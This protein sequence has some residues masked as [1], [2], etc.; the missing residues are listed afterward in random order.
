MALVLHPNVWSAHGAWQIRVMQRS[1]VEAGLIV[2]DPTD[3]W[4]QALVA[5]D[6]VI[7]DHGSVTLYGAATGHPVL[8]GAFG[9]ESVPGTAGQA[10]RTAAGWLDDDGAPLRPRLE[11]ALSAHGDHPDRFTE[12]TARAFVEPGMA[13]PR[14]RELAYDLLR[15][16]QPRH[17]PVR[18]AQGPR[19][20]RAFPLP[21]SQHAARARSFLVHTTVV[22]DDGVRGAGVRDDATAMGELHVHVSRL[23]AGLAAEPVEEGTSFWHLACDIDEPDTRLT[24]SASVVSAGSGVFAP[25]AAA[26]GVAR[27]LADFP[28]ARIAAVSREADCLVG[29]R[30][31]RTVR[32]A[33]AD[34]P[35]PGPQDAPHAPGTP[36]VPPAPDAPHIPAASPA[37]D[38]LAPVDPGL[39]AAVVYACLRAGIPPHG[40][41]H[42]FTLVLHLGPHR[43]RRLELR[44]GDAGRQPRASR[45]RTVAARG[46]PPSS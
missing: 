23:P 39:A 10:L 6:L 1:A 41:T 33:A 34:A 19:G 31:G 24:E 35:G 5:S 38:S 26:E 17:M 12:V 20:P 40:T 21:P 18:G 37:P 36:P 28:G 8:L 43:G 15:L 13:L 4:Q 7:G 32:V 14:L 25:G 9:S 44:P 46:L 30:D 42:G 11:T 45:S 22:R 16:P 2:V 27:L 29:L 3:G